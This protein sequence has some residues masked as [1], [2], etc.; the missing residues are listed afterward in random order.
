MSRDAN[1][2]QGVPKLP[3]RV[4][5]GIPTCLPAESRRD[6]LDKSVNDGD[7][8]PT[9]KVDTVRTYIRDRFIADATVT[10]VL[11]GRCTW[12]SKHVE[13]EIGSSLRHT[14][15]NPTCGL[16]GTLL[17]MH[18]NFRGRTFRE[19]A[20]TAEARRQRGLRRRFRQDLQLAAPMRQ[21]HHP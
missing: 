9:L 1:N 11:V 17:P 19:N 5:L 18:P 4:G 20:G 13:W 14:S 21:W 7:I 3:R 15:N 2:T 16:L 12:Q 6:I 8:D 10:M